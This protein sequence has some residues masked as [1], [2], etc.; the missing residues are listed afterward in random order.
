MPTM[1]DLRPELLAP[2]GSPEA[3]HAAIE[4]GADA[5]YLGAT[6][7]SAR[8]R[9]QNFDETALLDA[10]TLCRA[11]GVRTYITVNTRLRDAEIPDVLETV[12][13]LYSA[14]ADAL[15][16]A[17]LGAA[18]TIR[19]KYPEIEL[20]A[21][22]QLSGVSAADA[23][24]LQKLGFCRMVCPREMSFQQ[25]R[26]LCAASPLEIEMFIH[27]AH[28]VSYSGQCLFSYAMGGRSGN[29]GECAQ[30]CRLPFSLSCSCGGNR[31]PY[32][33]SLKDMCLAGHIT[34][35]LESGAASLK[36]EGRQKSPDY[37]YGV[38]RMYRTLLDEGRNASQEEIAALSGLF[39]RDG[40]SDGYWKSEPRNMLGIR[41]AQ[42]T[43]NS[44]RATPF[45]G[46]SRKIP[47]EAHL[48]VR[49]NTP[50]TL[51]LHAASHTVT[52]CGAVPDSARTIR[53]DADTARKNIEKLGG[54]PYI[55]RDFRAEIDDGLFC[56]PAQ[57][58]QLRRQGIA[59]LQM[60]PV[61]RTETTS[62]P[63]DQAS[64]AHPESCR[65]TA[66]FLTP[67]QI[68]ENASA[69]F[70]TI[71]TPWQ[72]CR[73]GD[74]ILLPPYATDATL[75]VI[76]QQL[77]QSQSP[78]SLLVHSMAQLALARELQIPAVASERFNV[79]NRLS[80]REILALG[81][82]TITASPEIPLGAVRAMPGSKAVVAYGRLP[83]LTMLRCALSDGGKNCRVGGCGGFTET[84][85]K[86][87]LCTG[88]L[89]DRTG[90][91]FPLIGLYDCVNLLYNSVPIY[92][93]DRMNLLRSA[94]VSVFHFIFT[95]ETRE[96]AAAVIHAYKNAAPPKN[97]G[98]VRRLK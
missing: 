47:L 52:V 26:A 63:S 87:K 91:E 93:A 24:E 19:Q 82:Q 50:L 25:V 32:P 1:T 53:L 42:D 69:F 14:G 4:G 17:D 54:T 18:G 20:H 46:L 77:Q 60:P 94:G 84:S 11:Y 96:E 13:L 22:T 34:E 67:T 21:S 81:A 74:G 89:T 49:S 97:P 23:A 2:A 35:I 85:E 78:P 39:S 9:A 76:R 73:P 30:P 16:L 6:R 15:I 8:M 66:Q 7:F 80:A 37:V 28:C 98:A 31:S 68:P 88:S 36:I 58:N 56:T 55:L 92:M 61:R 29:R 86:K 65:F 57:L 41:R 79:F 59:A 45:P 71:Y 3:L 70:D 38:T 72:V 10:I 27:G 75:S 5:V 48:Q 12:D 43:E 90:V 64:P 95:T 44:R 33:L 62:T 51:T 83:L 40:F